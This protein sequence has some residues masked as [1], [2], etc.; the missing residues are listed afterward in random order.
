MTATK[1]LAIV[2]GALLLLVAAQA[3]APGPL[4]PGL[5]PPLDRL[6]EPG[7]VWL[8]AAG[9]IGWILA[10]LRQ[11]RSWQADQGD[12]SPAERI[13][14]RRYAQGEL[15]HEQFVRMMSDLRSDPPPGA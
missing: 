13:L 4:L 14:R 2:G 12:G 3:I 5:G 8:V 7:L 1:S 11:S 6:F 15:D 9:G 10:K